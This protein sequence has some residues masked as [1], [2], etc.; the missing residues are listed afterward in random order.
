MKHVLEPF[1]GF[2]LNSRSGVEALVPRFDDVDSRPGV[3]GSVMGEKS[4]EIGVMQHFLGRREKG[5]VFADLVRWKLSTKYHFRP[6]LLSDGTFKQG[7]A[8]FDSVLD[9]E[10]NDRIR[11]SFRSS[12]DIAENLRDE[13]LSIEMKTKDENRFHLALFSTGVNQFLVRQRGIQVGGIQ[14]FLD[15]RLRLEFHVNYDY[16][17]IVS[18][19]AALA[20]VTPCIA[21]SVRYSHIALNTSSALSKEDRMDFVV[22]LRSL[23]DFK[24]FSR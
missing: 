10:P 6:I 13:S 7:W 24:L 5:E 20:Y 8:S 16:H 1:L 11:V 9:A 18:S 3:D 22:S 14:R 12:S 19:E 15:D 2:T 4:V 17:K 23:G 21:T